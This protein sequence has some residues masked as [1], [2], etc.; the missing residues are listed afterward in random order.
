[1]FKKYKF[2]FLFLFICLQGFAQNNAE[3]KEGIL[4]RHEGSLGISIHSQGFGLTYR[5]NKHITGKRMR[6][7]EIDILTVK[8]PKEIKSLNQYYDKPRSFVYGKLNSLLVL[9]GG[10]GLKNILYEKDEPGNIEIRY[11]FCGGASIGFAKP[12]YLYVLEESNDPYN[13]DK[14]IVKFNPDEHPIDVIYGKAPV[15]YGLE[16]TI[17]HPGLYAKGGIS[18]DWATDD[19]KVRNL[20]IGAVCDYYFSPIQLMAYNKSTP[21]FTTLYATLAFGRKWN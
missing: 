21:F 3:V 5:N 18:F 12:I 20:E 2:I 13:P 16:R 15:G 6:S 4:Y 14:V 7:F 19:E 1:M 17:I 10:I 9:R 11:N 8:H